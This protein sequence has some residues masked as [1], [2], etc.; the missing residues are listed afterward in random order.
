MKMLERTGDHLKN[1]AEEIIFYA[2]AKVLKHAEK[3]SEM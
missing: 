1:I 3:K 2:E